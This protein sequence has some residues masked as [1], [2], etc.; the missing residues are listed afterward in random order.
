MGYR[1]AL[2]RGKLIALRASKKKLERAY[3]NSLTGYLK[4]LKQKEAISPKRSRWYEKIKLI[5]EIK[6]VE[7]K[8]TVQ[9]IHKTRSCFFEEINKIN[10][11]LARLAREHRKSIQINKIRSEEG[12]I[13]TE[14]EGKKSDPTTKGYIQQNWKIWRK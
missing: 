14:T 8:R 5:P 7:T 9:R 10:K 2:L 12:D 4:V 1:K 6:Q 3:T 11:A 13:T